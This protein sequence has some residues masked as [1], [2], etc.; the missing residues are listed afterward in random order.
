[1]RPRLGDL[2]VFEVVDQIG[3][4]D[5]GKPMSD[6]NG[7][8]SLGDVVENL[9]DDFLGSTIE[10]GL[11]QKGLNEIRS[12]CRIVRRKQSAEGSLCK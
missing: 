11:I 12:V 9:C 1:M 5:T 7:G 10:C 8:T 2:S 4:L 6:R 3:M